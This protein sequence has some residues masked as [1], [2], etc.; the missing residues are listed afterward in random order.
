MVV[1]KQT[2]GDVGRLVINA[3][4]AVGWA[5]FISSIFFLLSALLNSAQHAKSLA[6][7]ALAV[8]LFIMTFFIEYL[9]IFIKRYYGSSGRRQLTDL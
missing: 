2:P 8:A 3:L 1:R 7:V 9:L 5:T 6:S 4:A